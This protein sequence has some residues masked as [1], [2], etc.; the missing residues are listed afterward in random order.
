MHK[1]D[2][3]TQYGVSFRDTRKEYLPGLEHR[4][5]VMCRRIIRLLTGIKNPAL[6]SLR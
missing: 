4:P 6:T 1:F 5:S 2:R 3:L